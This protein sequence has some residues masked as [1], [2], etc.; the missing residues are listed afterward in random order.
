[1][2]SLQLAFDERVWLITLAVK[3][4]FVVCECNGLFTGNLLLIHGC[5]TLVIRRNVAA[6]VDV[7]LFVV[8]VG[9][10]RTQ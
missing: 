7:V 2:S 1:M 8:C 4:V 9:C 6:T 3:T 10:L 5:F